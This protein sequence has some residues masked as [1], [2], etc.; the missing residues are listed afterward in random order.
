MAQ[1]THSSFGLNPLARE[2]V[3]IS[4]ASTQSLGQSASLRT[5][6]A[7]PASAP[8]GPDAFE[9][10]PDEARHEADYCAP[11]VASNRNPP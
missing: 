10:L 6:G 4:Y 11:H 3:P 1:C 2:F 5:G 7:A 8:T 9:Q